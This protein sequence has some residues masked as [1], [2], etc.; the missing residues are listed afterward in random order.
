M[1]H[2]KNT[3]FSYH[4]E[5]TFIKGINLDIDKGEC[6]LICGMSGSGK[7]T[8]SRI[9]NGLAPEYIEGELSG[10]AITDDLL[11]GESNLNEYVPIVGSVFQ[12]PKTQHFATTTE[13]EIALVCENLGINPD[14]IWKRILRLADIYETEHLLN[15]SLFEL[16]GGEKQQI[17]FLSAILHEPKV[18]VLDEITSNLDQ[19]AIK[20]LSKMIKTLKEK[21]MTIVLTEHR[22]AWSLDFVDRYIFLENGVID[23]IWSNEEMRE[24]DD[25]KLHNHGLRT[26]N[27]ESYR[28]KINELL[29]R[30]ATNDGI[31]QTNDL[32]IGYKDALLKPINISFDRGQI[33]GILGPNGTGKSTFANTLSGL[34]AALSGDIL[35]NGKKQSARQM[36]KRTFVVMQDTNYQLFTESVEEEITLGLDEDTDIKPLLEQLNLTKLRDKHPMS[37]SGGEKQRVA[38]ASAV[39]SGKELIIYDEPTSGLDYYHMNAFG[40]EIKKLASSGIIQ[41]IIT[42]DEELAAE[43]CDTII[44]LSKF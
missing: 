18:I 23:S 33:I 22:L 35:W 36:T 41:I 13:N 26:N 44:D 31:L 19:T 6:I 9:I 5:N 34:Q 15:R 4:G 37:L 17:A 8:L 29:N 28:I 10:T 16:S 30:P 11:A 14:L 42:H 1:I 27:L 21:G 24:M 40:K 7:T 32:V 39:Q 43:F 38:I 20:R 12:N 2:L 25:L 3:S